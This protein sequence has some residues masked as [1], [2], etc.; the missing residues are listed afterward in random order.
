MYW[1]ALAMEASAARPEGAAGDHRRAGWLID[2]SGGARCEPGGD[3][4]SRCP[5]RPKSTRGPA[6]INSARGVNRNSAATAP[7]WNNTMA[8]T[9]IQLCCGRY[10]TNRPIDSWWSVSYE[11]YVPFS[12]IATGNDT[13]L[14]S[15]S[16]GIKGLKSEAK[17]QPKAGYQMRGIPEDLRT[18]RAS[19][20]DPGPDSGRSAYFGARYC[21]HYDRL[22][23][24]RRDGPAPVPR[25]HGR[26]TTRRPP[27]RARQ[28]HR[29]Q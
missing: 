18:R 26:R 17:L 29:G 12:D 8:T 6:A 25:R 28:R 1:F 5:N 23:L 24:D 21:R 15:L 11:V 27:I 4:P 22:W 14:A 20:P 16:N 7:A 10:R 3:N 9:V 13:W 19:P 2:C